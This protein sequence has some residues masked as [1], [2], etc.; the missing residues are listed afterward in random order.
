MTMPN[1]KKPEYDWTDDEFYDD[2]WSWVDESELVEKA[3]TKEQLVDLEK[4]AKKLDVNG[5][6]VE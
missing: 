3:A 2:A 4:F 6:L 5:G 1:E